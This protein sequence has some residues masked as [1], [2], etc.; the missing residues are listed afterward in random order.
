MVLVPLWPLLRRGRRRR[1]RSERRR[2]EREKKLSTCKKKKQRN[3]LFHLIISSF[4]RNRHLSS[5]ESLQIL[6]HV[7][8]YVSDRGEWFCLGEVVEAGV[9]IVRSGVFEVEGNKRGGDLL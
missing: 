7:V 5:S 2:R 3:S 9:F 8:S 4:H 6:A 1:A